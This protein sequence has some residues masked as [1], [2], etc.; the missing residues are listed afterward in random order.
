MPLPLS[1][2]RCTVLAAG[3][4]LVGAGCEPRPAPT[5]EVAVEDDSTLILPEAPRGLTGTLRIAVAEGLM[6]I[7]ERQAELFRRD[8]P[9]LTIELLRRSSRG[10]FVAFLRDS[11]GVA[12]VDRPMNADE[13]EVARLLGERYD[14]DTVEM[15]MDAL[16]VVANAANPVDSLSRAQLARLV[17]GGPAWASV[18][19][20]GPV[21]PVE[22]VLPSRNNATHEV[23]ETSVAPGG[24]LT[25]AQLA[26][27][28]AGV[29]AVVAARPAALGVVGLVALRDSVRMQG[30]KVLAVSDTF[31]AARPGQGSVYRREYPL[32][33]PARVYLSR[34]AG[35]PESAF[36]RFA[37]TTSA[38][39]A[40]Q[41]AGLVP[42]VTPAHRI[43]LTPTL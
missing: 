41:D 10:A 34:R 7:V 3:L 1:V 42:A 5:T 8:H 11:V 38:Q 37:K 43:I 40:V 27:D 33:V 28:P 15:G 18:V 30:V 32:R 23:L 4:A 12:V 20:G 29:L 39:R 36:A 9:G 25:L 14:L 2:L 17:R 16:A 26:A 13:A 22:L 35:S 24:P 6:P 19:P 31:A 21:S